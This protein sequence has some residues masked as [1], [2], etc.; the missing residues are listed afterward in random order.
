[1]HDEIIVLERKADC[2]WAMDEGL[3][4]SVFIIMLCVLQ[5]YLARLI[6]VEHYLDVIS[7]VRRVCILSD[8][9]QNNK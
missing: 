9:S 3:G 5:I 4:F 1:M 2:D 6:V 8:I 7:R